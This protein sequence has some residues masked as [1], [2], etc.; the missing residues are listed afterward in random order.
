MVLPSGAGHDAMVMSRYL[1]SV[2][3]FV[4]SINGRSHHVS[5]NTSDEDLILGAQVML[6]AVE[7]TIKGAA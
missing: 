3:M 2:M 1:P 6:R 5:E 7:R 4:P